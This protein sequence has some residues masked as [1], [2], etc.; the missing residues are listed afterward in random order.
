MNITIVTLFPDMFSG[1]FEQSI[2]K[3]ARD[4]NLVEI[5]FV[6]IRE[7]GLGRHLVVD[8]T[9][10]GGGVGMILKVDVLHK[11]I[12]HAKKTFLKKVKNKKAK[13]LVVL[14]SASG[15]VYKQKRAKKYAALD[16]LIIVCG[17]YEGVDARISH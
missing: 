2:I 9:P 12:M 11:A 5:E 3:R 1:P 10:Y 8:D 16:H 6:N 4:K 7:F 15:K 14:T 17:H 13:Q